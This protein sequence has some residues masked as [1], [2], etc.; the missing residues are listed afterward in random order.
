M[1]TTGRARTTDTERGARPRALRRLVLLATL[2]GLLMTLMAPATPASA[3]ASGCTLA[4][5]YTGALNCISVVGSGLVVSSSRSTYVPGV[6]PWPENL[7][8]R[9]HQWRYLRN[10]NTSYVTR[11]VNA[12]G[13]IVGVLNSYVDWSGPG[14]M[15]NNSSF[16]ARSKNSHT[17]GVYSNYACVTIRA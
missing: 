6:S 9:T 1:H 7:C 12:S 11:T 13:C 2:A 5:G 8:S 3:S 14:T 17:G 10:G 4:P 15:A 16:C